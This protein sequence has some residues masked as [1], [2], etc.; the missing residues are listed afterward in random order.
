MGVLMVGNLPALTPD[1]SGQLPVALVLSVQ[2]VTG[3]IQQH[4][5]PVPSSQEPDMP[6]T[7]K[8]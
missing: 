1:A 6:E 5:Y 8:S 7:T 2:L 3:Q 4:A